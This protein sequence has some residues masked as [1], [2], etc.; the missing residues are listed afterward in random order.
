MNIYAYN[1]SYN[2]ICLS[3]ELLSKKMYPCYSYTIPFSDLFCKSENQFF[4]YENQFCTYENQFCT[5]KNQFFTYEN[6]FC[7]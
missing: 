1:D 7:N 4:T 3:P 6:H 5:N 2:V